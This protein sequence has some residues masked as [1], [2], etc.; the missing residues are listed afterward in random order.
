MMPISDCKI[1]TS[2]NIL[3]SKNLQP[4]EAQSLAFNEKSQ[5]SNKEMLALKLLV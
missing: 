5:Q 1:L 2:E 3:K 4:T